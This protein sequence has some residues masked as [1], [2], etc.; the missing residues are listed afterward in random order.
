MSVSFQAILASY[1]PLADDGVDPFIRSRQPFTGASLSAHSIP[2]PP[3]VKPGDTITVALSCLAA[4][5]I[6]INTGVSGSDWTVQR[7][8]AGTNCKVWVATK[9]A[10]GFD[11][12]TINLSVANTVVGAS[13]AVPNGTTVRSTGQAFGAPGTNT[14]NPPAVTGLPSSAAAVC[15]VVFSPNGST[16]TASAPAG[17]TLTT[18]AVYGQIFEAVKTLAGTSEDPAAYA[19]GANTAHVLA[20]VVLTVA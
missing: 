19:P 18:Q 4:P 1:G 6:T 3:S 12:L 20:T 7:D 2:M 16:T 13:Y 17:Y 8:N 10:T 5:T 9:I 15:F 11:A 14:A